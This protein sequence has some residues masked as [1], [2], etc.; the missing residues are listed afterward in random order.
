MARLMPPS[1]RLLTIEIN[2][3]Y[4]AITQQMVDFAGLQDKVTI[5]VGASQDII[6]QLKKKYDVDTLDMVF[7]DHWKDRYLPDTLL[8]EVSCTAACLGWAGCC[9]RGCPVDGPQAL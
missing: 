3:A 9:C 4:A 5:V 8:L 7:L 6:P 1:A 2:P